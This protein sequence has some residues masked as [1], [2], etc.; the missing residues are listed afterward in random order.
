MPL[1]VWIRAAIFP[2][3]MSTRIRVSGKEAWEY[4]RVAHNRILVEAV[5]LSH[6]VLPVMPPRNCAWRRR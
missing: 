3:S 5:R 2:I 6:L 4:L 1:Q